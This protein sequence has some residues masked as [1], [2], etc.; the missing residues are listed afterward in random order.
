[1]LAECLSFKSISTDVK[2]LDEINVTVDWY[3]QLFKS[4]GIEPEVVTGYDNPFVVAKIIV[5]PD[6][7]RCLVYG[8]Y[9]V[10]PANLSD[11]W[12]QDPF[13]LRITD[14]RLY[15]RG[16]VDNKGQSLI[17]LVTILESFANKKLTKNIVFL[18]E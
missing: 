5:N 10:Q 16:V 9:D 6:L 15:G 13:T 17:H 1:L 7:P 11:G 8:H 4:Y 18:L 3:V 12:Q 2:Y 14:E